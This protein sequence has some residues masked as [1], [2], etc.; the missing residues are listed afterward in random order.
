VGP[1]DDESDA[2]EGLTLDEDFVRR[3][4]TRELTAE[5]R[6]RRARQE[7]EE[8]ERIAAMRQ[9]HRSQQRATRRAHRGSRVKK[10]GSWVVLVAIIAGV[11]GYQVFVE[12]RRDDEPA[13][14]ASATATTTV[15]AWESPEAEA[16]A[17]A[18]AP[19]PDRPTPSV[20]KTSVRMSSRPPAPTAPGRFRFLSTQTGTDAPVAYDP[21]RVIRVVINERT[22]PAGAKG[23]V[24]DVLEEVGLWTGLSFEVEGPTDEGASGDRADYQPA[25]YGDRWAPVLVVWSDPGEDPVLEGGVAG[26]AG[27]HFIET[28]HGAVYVTGRVSLD[29]PDLGR[30]I[31]AGGRRGRD[32]AGD[33]IRH[34]VGHLVG[35]AH[36]DEPSELM[37][38]E[39]RPRRK[40]GYGPGDV[41]G[42]YE[43]GGGACIP[44]L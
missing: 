15:P 25:K 33:I 27:S 43:L 37:F 29:G 2:L 40:F 3:A 7:A 23:L 19:G 1:S 14:A 42:L 9:A 6:A 24:Q 21:C 8:D 44:V 11:V 13:T 5:D 41:R 18:V 36:I 34:E 26:N 10:I 31:A 39:G 38:P 32:Y 20:A 22:M 17:E 16:D 35:L 12:R 4:S 28:R 30:I